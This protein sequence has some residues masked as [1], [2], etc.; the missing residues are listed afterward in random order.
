MT[1]SIKQDVSCNLI[2]VIRLSQL[3]ADDAN[4]HNVDEYE[5]VAKPCRFNFN[6]FVVN[7]IWH[8]G[9]NLSLSAFTTKI[10]RRDERLGRG[11]PK[12]E[13]PAHCCSS[14]CISIHM[15]LI[16]TLSH[17]LSNV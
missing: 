8:F 4:D 9:G 7:F 12:M 5:L 11:F 13:R 17:K 2:Y 6:D 15:L 3:N 16:D 14:F 1:V 10:M